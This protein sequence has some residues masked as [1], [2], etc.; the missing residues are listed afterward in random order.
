MVGYYMI[1][2]NAESLVQRLVAYETK[3]KFKV[4][5]EKSAS[6]LFSAGLT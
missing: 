5:V 3:G 4:T 2:D 6:I 1:I